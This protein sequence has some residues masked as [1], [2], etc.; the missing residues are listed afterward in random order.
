M[1]AY[2]DNFAVPACSFRDLLLPHIAVACRTIDEVTGMNL[3]H[4]KCVAGCNTDFSHAQTSA[5]GV[6]ASG[7]DGRDMK[8][9]ENC[10][11]WGL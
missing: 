3:H 4:R 9:A 8:M 1:C 7:P 5:T 11:M 10:H 6:A 2:A